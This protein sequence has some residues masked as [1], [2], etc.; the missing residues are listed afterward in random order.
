MPEPAA[1]IV[2]TLVVKSG[3]RYA[4]AGKMPDLGRKPRYAGDPF[5]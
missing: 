5:H 2:Y 1:R 4:A 3:G